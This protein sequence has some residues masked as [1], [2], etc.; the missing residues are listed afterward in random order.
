MIHRHCAYF[1]C[2]ACFDIKCDIVCMWLP[3]YKTLWPKLSR[4]TVSLTSLCCK[5]RSLWLPAM[6]LTTL[7]STKS[8]QTARMVSEQEAVRPN[9]LHQLIGPRQ[10]APAWSD[11]IGWLV[12][13][14][15]LGSFQCQGVL[16]IWHIVGLGPTRLSYLP[17]LMPHLLGDSWTYWNI[18]VSAVIT[19]R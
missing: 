18:V 2:S 13:A 11:H 15:V 4:W 1:C 17:F 5:I 14:M 6:S 8:S 7:M 12:P 10:E 3:N 19:Q 9:F 16:L